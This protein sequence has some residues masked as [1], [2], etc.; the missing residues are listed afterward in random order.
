M[1]TQ[2]FITYVTVALSFHSVFMVVY[3]FSERSKNKIH[4][5]LLGCAFVLLGTWYITQFLEFSGLFKEYPY[6]ISW[7]TFYIPFLIPTLY[8]YVVAV[9]SRRPWHLWQQSKWHWIIAGIILAFEIPV[10]VSNA[11]I[12][13]SLYT[14]FSRLP[15]ASDPVPIF[16]SKISS[17]ML[18]VQ[19][20][21]YVLLSI[22]RLIR[23]DKHIRYFF[24]NLEN[25]TL[26]WLRNYISLIFLLWLL[27]WIDFIEIQEGYYK[28]IY[29]FYLLWL[30][31]FSILGLRQDRVFTEIDE[32]EI[33]TEKEFSTKQ[34]KPVKQRISD[35]RRIRIASK[36]RQVMEQDNL[37]KD[38]DLTLR[39]LSDVIGVS[40][41]HISE[42]LRD[43]IG[44][45]F[46]DYINECRINEACKLLAN[47]DAPTITIAYA[48]GF[49]SRSTFS[50]AFKKHKNTSPTQYRKAVNLVS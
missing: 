33:H 47:T 12:R 31:A 41:H 11:E 16:L 13:L 17:I 28:G 18:M 38:A 23:H 43:E 48:S 27:G 30:L 45:N 20:G 26:V 24:S 1:N 7:T 3:L 49:N 37:Y 9:S 10:L 22:K 35:D 21:M 46:Y 8:F 2:T 25:R 36:L 4:F 42:T 40:T 32:Q 39:K 19:S 6:L 50:A 15:L 44:H 29:S 34:E 5:Q 14:D